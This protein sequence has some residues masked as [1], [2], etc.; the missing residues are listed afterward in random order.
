MFAA[1]ML[2]LVLLFVLPFQTSGQ[3]LSIKNS[4]K[5]VT[6]E[7]CNGSPNWILV[8]YGNINVPQFHGSVIGMRAEETSCATFHY[9]PKTDGFVIVHVFMQ[10][11]STSNG[12]DVSLFKDAETSP[13]ETYVYKKTND[14]LWNQWHDLLIH[15]EQDTQFIRLTGT[16]S[17]D[18]I[19]IVDSLEFVSNDLMDSEKYKTKK[20]L[21][22]VIIIEQDEFFIFHNVR[23]KRDNDLDDLEDEATTDEPVQVEDNDEN[24][25]WT[26]LTISLITIGGVAVVAALLGAA[27][28]YGFSKSESLL[29]D[30][31]EEPQRTVTIPRVRDVYN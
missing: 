22:P 18:D 29:V 13:Q 16:S 30:D 5:T 2:L 6:S 15:V 7:F 25:F 4:Y 3:H 11:S 12:I 23:E 19:I 20:V 8:K 17:K 21:A 1:N 28:Y 26:P 14:Q 27:Y 31:F 24:G 9:A 10:V